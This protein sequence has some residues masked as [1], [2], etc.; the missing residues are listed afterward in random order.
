MRYRLSQQYSATGCDSRIR[1]L[2][3]HFTAVDLP[4]ALRLLS[5]DVSAHYLISDNPDDPVFNLISEEKRAWH[6]G[7][8]GWGER[9]NL[10]DC[11]IGIEIVNESTAAGRDMDDFRPYADA[12]IETV[13]DLS[14]DIVKRHEI[15]PTHVLGHADIAPTRKVD[16]GPTFPWQRLAQA[17]IGAWYDEADKEQWTARYRDEGVPAVCDIQQ[18]LAQYGYVVAQTG[19]LDDAT[20]HCLRAFQMHFRPSRYDGKI[21]IETAAILQALLQ[22]Y[23]R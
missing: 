1:F 11:S 15:K 22:K 20:Y 9:R 23:C 7:A 13:I 19:E 8:S 4:N 5:G 14:R 10:N 16:P 3:F 12:Q 6:A 17:G 2:I 18:S 21:D